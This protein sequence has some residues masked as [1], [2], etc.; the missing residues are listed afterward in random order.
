MNLTNLINHYSFNRSN[1]MAN[2]II[3]ILKKKITETPL[4]AKWEEVGEVVE[5]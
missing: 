2:D 1:P 5:G 3:D 4:D